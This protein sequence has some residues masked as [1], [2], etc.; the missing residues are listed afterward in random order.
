MRLQA[1]LL[2]ALLLA[3]PAAPAA[4]AAAT[5]AQPAATSLPASSTGSAVPSTL[6]AASAAGPED[7]VTIRELPIAVSQVEPLTGRTLLPQV[8]A[9]TVVAETTVRDRVMTPVIDTGDVQTIG[10]TWSAASDG[11]RLLPQARYRTGGDWSPWHPLD[12]GTAPDAGTPDATTGLRGGTEPLWIGEATEVQLS[13]ASAA[14]TAPDDLE[15]ALVG[16]PEETSSQ[17]VEAALAAG[18]RRVIPRSEW[19]A[20]AQTCTPDTA[21]ALKGAV[22]HH[23]A[24]SNAY[25]TVAEA[26]QQLRNDALYHIRTRGWCDIGYN[27]VVD[28]WGNIYEGRARSLDLPVIGVHAGGFNTGFLGVS[29]LGTYDAAPPRA[30]LDSVGYIIGLRLGYY[31]VDPRQSAQFYTAGGENSKFSDQTVTLPRVFGHRDVAYTACPGNGGYSALP[32]IRD[33]AHWTAA[34]VDPPDLVRETAAGPT[35]LVT[36]THKYPV[37]D[38]D[39]LRMFGA[40]GPVGYVSKAFLDSKTTGDVLSRLILARDTMVY[41]VD[42]V[43]KY[44][45]GSCD[46]VWRWGFS[47]SQARLLDDAQI[48][49]FTTGPMMTTGVRVPSGRHWGIDAGKRR[50][51]PDLQSL[52]WAGFDGAPITVTDDAV[53]HLAVGQPAVRPDTVVVSRTS[54]R[55]FLVGAGQLVPMADG[56]L[57]STPIGR[58]PSGHLDSASLLA[59]PWSDEPLALFAGSAT[60]TATWLLNGATKSQIAD[61][62]ATGSPPRLSTAVL[63]LFTTSSSTSAPVLV[64]TPDS[65]AVYRMERNVRRSIPSWD[66]ALRITA[67]S[68]GPRIATVDSRVV[69]SLPQGADQ[70]GPGTLAY[71]TASASVYLI[72][73]FGTKHHIGSW[74]RMA[75]LGTGPLVLRREA[76][77]AA[78]TTAPGTPQNLVV[79]S[80]TSYLATGGRLHPVAASVAS[81]WATVPRTTLDA[82]TCANLVR[83]GVAVGRFL[84]MP[85]GAI[86]YV[87]NG[88]RR[89]ITSYATYRALGG[90]DRDWVAVN[91]DAIATIPVGPEI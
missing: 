18:S 35:Y 26:M 20:P 46:M 12:A 82:T 66:D 68:G 69:R 28:K 25:S 79:C 27:F 86:W 58:L 13:F 23:T 21:A 1:V 71:S 77:L 39:T 48:A 60:G 47:C 19:G 74:D 45:F 50:E 63:D 53:S 70:L 22:V 37:K 41:L 54:G 15:L 6:G 11:A 7:G 85:T 34:T 14:G 44:P 30:V 2:G 55:P 33:I 80:G 90:N 9:G 56:V 10:L 29:M 32:A 67:G 65:P 43:N 8:E 64:K 61:A 91:T 5:P 83:S 76:D 87:E 72:D 52:A 42:G 31:G 4:P 40:L 81:H 78:Y 36:S 59:M 16:T 73:G 89:N 17:P 3:G 57:P 62:A 88:T 38:A 75:N 84:R 24:G 49:E 51:A